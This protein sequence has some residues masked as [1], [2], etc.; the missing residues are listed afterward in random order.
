MNI[1]KEHGPKDLFNA[2]KY[3]SY[4]KFLKNEFDL[5][6]SKFREISKDEALECIKNHEAGSLQKMS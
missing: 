1:L 4:G 3:S 5:E 2:Y 6:N